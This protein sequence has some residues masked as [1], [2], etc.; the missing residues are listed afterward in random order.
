VNPDVMKDMIEKH[1]IEIMPHYNPDGSPGGFKVIKMPDGYR[2]TMLPAGAEFKTFDQ[3]TGQ[4][5]THKSSAPIT[6]GEVD[7][8]NHAAGIAG[9]KFA[10][11]KQEADLKAAQTREANA[12]AGKAPSEIRD[13]NARADA[14]E[15]AA[16]ESRAKTAQLKSGA[17]QADGTPNP[18]FEAMAQALYDGDV[19]PADLK[20]EAKGANLDP[21]EVMARAVEIGNANGHPWSAPI[22]EQENKFA[23]SPKTQAAL[24]GID[25][26]IGKPGDAT[27]GYMAQMLNAAQ[28]ADLGT[29]GAFNS[30][31]LA[32][33]RFF[34]G[35]QAKNFETA[36]METRRS[37]AGLI[38]NP[39]LGG[40]ETDKK[41]QQADAM[42]GE[43]PTMENLKGAAALLKTALETQRTSMIG[44]NRFLQRRYA[45]GGAAANAPQG[46]AF[47]SGAWAAANPGKDVNAAIAAAKQQGYQVVQ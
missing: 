45:Q 9:V 19:L 36:A 27:T 42:L 20:R 11:D 41:L 30:A 16:G 10:T 47:S 8:Y 12:N 31:G 22:I 7:D 15:A 35:T 1:Q 37:I 5:L 29:N 23:A 21:N 33:K 39:L 43:K 38:G 46:R 24:D 18:R 44:N 34:G 3:T 13:T 2:N 32:V 40:G 17:V 26:I 14:S 6:Q 25:R 4:Y 28:K